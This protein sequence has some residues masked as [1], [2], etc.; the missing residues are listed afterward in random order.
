[1]NDLKTCSDCVNFDLCGIRPMTNVHTCT[2]WIDLIEVSKTFKKNTNVL[3]R[4]RLSLNNNNKPIEQN[5]II[6]STLAT[7]N[8]KQ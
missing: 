5:S 6:K 4:I 7:Q 8:L 1:M 3:L 2:A